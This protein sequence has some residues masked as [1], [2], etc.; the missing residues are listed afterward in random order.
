MKP[1]ELGK[2]AVNRSLIDLEP[3]MP[4]AQGLPDRIYSAL[5]HRI[6]TCSLT[7]GQ[8]LLE[9]DLS[10]ELGVSR[11]PLREA[12]NRL[13]LESLVI[14]TPYRGYA[15]TPV[16]MED[17]RNLSE[18]RLIVEA[19][20]SALA[21][22]RATEEEITRLGKL[23][24]LDYTPGDRATYI[25]Y[26]RA[27]S[28]FHQALVFC[29]HNERLAAVAVSVLDQI[30]RPLYLGLD[31]GLEAEHAT[32][33]HYELV[34]AIRARDAGRARRVAAEQI[35]RAEMRIVAAVSAANLNSE[36]A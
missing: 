25:R 26:L 1:G 5:K 13:A 10:I 32:A 22:E 30:Q 9:K 21:A 23:A 11:T 24:P 14:L 34:A 12:L 15:V 28:A 36:E 20:A 27:N 29:S 18:V 6:L 31:T 17:I 7:P 35:R 19:E 8:R 4:L 3:E 33:E 16:R 2:R